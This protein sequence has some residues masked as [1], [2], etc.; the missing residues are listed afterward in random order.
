MLTGKRLCV[1]GL[2]IVAVVALF[3]RHALISDTEQAKYLPPFMARVDSLATKL[4]AEA[5]AGHQEERIAQSKILR[6]YVMWKLGSYENDTISRS[7]GSIEH[8]QGFDN[9]DPLW[10][11]KSVIFFKR[12]TDDP[13]AESSHH[14]SGRPGTMQFVGW[15]VDVETGRSTGFYL[16]TPQH[17][18]FTPTAILPGDLR[19]IQKE[20]SK[21]VQSHTVDQ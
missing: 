13:N 17:V 18:S 8:L 4:Q 3:V 5:A 21:W 14:A 19:D 7:S 9:A 1:V 20:F 12:I 6:P 2:L 11:A 15:V 16:G 10:S